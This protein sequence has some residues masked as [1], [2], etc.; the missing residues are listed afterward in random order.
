MSSIVLHR[1]KGWMDGWMGREWV[2]LR[3]Y[4]VGLDWIGVV[5]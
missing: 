1:S 5:S 3:G 4:L 2:I